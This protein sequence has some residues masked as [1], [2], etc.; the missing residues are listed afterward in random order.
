MPV[1]VWDL[2]PQNLTVTLNRNALSRKTLEPNSG[3]LDNWVSFPVAADS[4]FRTVSATPSVL[5]ILVVVPP[6]GKLTLRSQVIQVAV[7]PLLAPVAM[8]LPHAVVDI[9]SVRVSTPF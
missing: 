5:F 1:A 8:I 9:V 7:M 4:C 6:L 2:A 3:S